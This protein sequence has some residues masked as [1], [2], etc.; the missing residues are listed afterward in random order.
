M[1]YRVDIVQTIRAFGYVEVECASAAEASEAVKR[2]ADL[3]RYGPFT[4]TWT[5]KARLGSVEIAAVTEA[6]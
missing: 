3:P 1:K 2:L 6:G 5:D 4:P